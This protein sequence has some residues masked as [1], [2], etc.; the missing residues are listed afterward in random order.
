MLSYQC[1]PFSLPP[2]LPRSL[3]VYCSATAFSPWGPLGVG[4][5]SAVFA[6]GRGRGCCWSAFD[7][8]FCLAPVSGWGSV[9]FPVQGLSIRR[10]VFAPG[11]RVWGE[12]KILGFLLLVVAKT[13]VHFAAARRTKNQSVSLEGQSV[14]PIDL[15]CKCRNEFVA[16]RLRRL[17]DFSIVR[18]AHAGQNFEP[19]C[20]G[21]L[22]RR[23]NQFSIVALPF[24]LPVQNIVSG[25]LCLGS[26]G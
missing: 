4:F 15:L 14:F 8:R 5:A 18:P 20:G 6:P 21:S 25:F 3:I 10:V 22:P 17:S 26:G 13:F 12:L 2:P 16:W 1:R 7:F 24:R 11:F 23:D 19:P 9:C